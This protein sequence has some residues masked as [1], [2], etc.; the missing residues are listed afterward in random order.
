MRWI[1]TITTLAVALAL[2][3]C[4]AIVQGYREGVYEKKIAEIKAQADPIIAECNAKH[5]KQRG[6]NVNRVRCLRPAQLLYLSI[7]PFPDLLEQQYAAGLVVAEKQDN[8]T[9]TAPQAELEMAQLGSRMEAEAQR[10]NLAGRSV[11]ANEAVAAEAARA[12]T[13]TTLNN[14]QRSINPPTVT[15]THQP[16]GFGHLATSTCQ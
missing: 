14:L 1:A 9:I 6:Q 11:M 3:G 4:G 5:P 12:N 8:G 16:G 15:C 10:R 2:G 7:S 13:I